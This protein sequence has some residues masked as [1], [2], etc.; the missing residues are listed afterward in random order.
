MC[1]LWMSV[2]QIPVFSRVAQM[3]SRKPGCDC[4]LPQCCDRNTILVLFICG[5]NE[6]SSTQNCWT[7]CDFEPLECWVRLDAS[8]SVRQGVGRFKGIAACCVA[9]WTVVFEGGESTFPLIF[10]AFVREIHCVVFYQN[11]SDFFLKV[12]RCVVSKRSC[13]EKKGNL[14]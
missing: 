10:Y 9:T 3:E 14:L 8:I 5:S 12:C 13:S 6:C 2:K 1:V 11:N 4:M 7:C